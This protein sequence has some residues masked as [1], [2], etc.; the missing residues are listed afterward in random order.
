MTYF[1]IQ[2]AKEA[3]KKL[4]CLSFEDFNISFKVYKIANMIDESF[5]FL[6]NEIEKLKTKYGNPEIGKDSK[7]KMESLEAAI[8]NPFNR[9]GNFQG[10]F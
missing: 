1:D 7:K 3:F 9:G 10:F 6:G 4:Y 2:S 5:V 8:K